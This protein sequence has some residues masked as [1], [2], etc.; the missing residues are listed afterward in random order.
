MSRNNTEHTAP[1][2][3]PSISPSLSRASSWSDT[4]ATGPPADVRGARDP[5]AVETVPLPAARPD[6]RQIYK[7]YTFVFSTD[8]YHDE[9]RVYQRNGDAS[10]SNSIRYLKPLVVGH[11]IDHLPPLKLP[12]Y[13]VAISWTDSEGKERMVSTPSR[14]EIR[15]CEGERRLLAQVVVV[16]SAR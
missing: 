9:T 4:S 15:C 12:F 3:S 8:A 13:L 16:Q 14:P 5:L 6:A 2:V 10:A 11:R 1:A 7:G